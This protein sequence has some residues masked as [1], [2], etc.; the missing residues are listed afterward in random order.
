MFFCKNKVHL[1][2]LNPIFSNW[3]KGQIPSLNLQEWRLSNT[4][5][6]IPPVEGVQAFNHKINV[7]YCCDEPALWSQS[8]G[9]VTQ[10][11]PHGFV[12][13]MLLYKYKG[14][15]LKEAHK[16]FC[17]RRKASCFSTDMAPHSATLSSFDHLRFSDKDKIKVCLI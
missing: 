1:S 8:V 4:L 3:L 9:T 6:N 10:H 13:V 5:G 11:R 2:F 14:L 12:M 15:L 16:S 7:L 17:H